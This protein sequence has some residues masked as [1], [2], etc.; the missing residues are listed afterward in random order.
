MTRN[1]AISV[2]I[3]VY[4]QEKYVSKCIRSVLSQTFQNF[5]IVLVNDG[6]TDKSLKICQKYAS[7]DHRVSI[8]DKPN[9]GLAPARKDGFLITK[10]EYICFLDSDDYL[11]PNAFN[12]L[13]HIAEANDVDMVIGNHSIVWDNWLLVKKDSIPYH[14]ANQ[15]INQNEVISFMLQNDKKNGFAASVVWGRIVRKSVI[16]NAWEAGTVLFPNNRI[17]DLFFNLAITPFLHSIWLTNQIVHYYR[18]GGFTTRNASFSEAYGLYFDMKFDY[19]LKSCTKEDLAKTNKSIIDQ[20]IFILKVVLAQMIHYRMSTIN[21]LREIIKRELME[22]KILLWAR[23]NFSELSV[24]MR[25]DT[26]IQA[27]LNCDMDV[28]LG[29]VKEHEQFLRKHYYW[30]MNILKYYQ[31]LVDIIS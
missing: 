1:P 4:N 26:L 8:I 9:E 7:K 15:L 21:D 18:Y 5:E 12:I 24:E 14:Y 10:G 3:P 23:Q 13:Y 2:I 22:R 25:Q 11:A 29:V 31:R 19:C 27:V 20:Y 17:E 6:S 16:Q 30:K 28:F